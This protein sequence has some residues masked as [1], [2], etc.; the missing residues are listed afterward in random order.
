MLYSRMGM[1]PQFKY[2]NPTQTNLHGIWAA[3]LS[4]ILNT[5]MSHG[6]RQAYI[7]TY[8][9]LGPIPHELLKHSSRR[10]D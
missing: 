7:Q 10:L 2:S 6:M 1:T 5:L 4:S 9:L 8:G 3:L